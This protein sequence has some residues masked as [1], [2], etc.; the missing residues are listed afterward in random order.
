M[1]LYKSIDLAMPVISNI[2]HS[3]HSGGRKKYTVDN[4]KNKSER[5]GH[6]KKF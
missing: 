2:S 4:A 1:I 6:R 3:G 5:L